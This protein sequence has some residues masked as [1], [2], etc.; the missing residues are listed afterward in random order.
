MAW[1]AVAQA[2]QV[3]SLGRAACR[4]IENMPEAMFRISMG[5]MNGDSRPGPRLKQNPCVARPW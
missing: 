5:I 3:A 1:L 4:Y 2:E